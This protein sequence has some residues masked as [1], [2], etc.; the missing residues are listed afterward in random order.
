MITFQYDQWYLHTTYM[1]QGTYIVPYL[2]TIRRNDFP[3]EQ[4]MTIPPSQN[5]VVEVGNDQTNSRVL[6]LY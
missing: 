4:L 5:N 6:V 1:V 2:H 3:I